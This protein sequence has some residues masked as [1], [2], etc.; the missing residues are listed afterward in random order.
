MPKQ[1]KKFPKSADFGNFDTRL[2]P[3]QNK[4]ETHFEMHPKVVFFNQ[5]ASENFWQL[6]FNNKS[7]TS[8]NQSAIS[9]IITPSY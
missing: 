3:R 8:F 1:D 9:A 2:M 6:V 5:F 4:W 7:H